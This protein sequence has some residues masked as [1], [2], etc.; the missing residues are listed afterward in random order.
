M[1]QAYP[2]SNDRSAPAPIG[3]PI[4]QTESSRELS[5]DAT[6]KNKR[7]S[8]S[9]LSTL[10]WPFRQF[11]RM[12]EWFFGIFS[13]IW[14]LTICAAIPIL[15]FITLGYLLK[16]SA[17]IVQQQKLRAGFVGIRK[18]ARIGGFV[19]GTT[20]VWF[21]AFSSSGTFQDAQILLIDPDKLRPYQINLTTIIL[22]TIPYTLWAWI[23]GAKLRHFLWPAPL[24]FFRSVGKRKTY[25]NAIE[26]FW[27]FVASLQLKELFM[28]GLR[29]FLGT[30][31]WLLIPVLLCIGGTQL[32]GILRVLSPLLGLPMLAIVLIYLP[33]LQT[34]FAVEKNFSVF[35][36]VKAVRAIF[37]R[38]PIALWISMLLVW[39]FALPVYLAKIQLTPREVFLL[40]TVIFVIFAWPSRM[41]MGWAYGRAEKRE[42]NR[43][44][45]SIWLSRLAII[46]IVFIFAGVVFLS[47]YTSWYGDWSL[48][49]QHALLI[50][51]PLLGG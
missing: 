7:Q 42:K 3:E 10:S 30:A 46:P 13:M 35:R 27:A 4:I 48:F 49:E 22:L 50:P 29:G 41:L 34:R 18:A 25:L 32:P 38:A 33:I 26:G 20:L 24:R 40:P 43:N 19:L 31:A 47:R 23:R 45:I 8:S 36:E 9:L 28:L 11:A 51:I 37:K 2:Q 39:A 5:E 17:E 16:M 15:Q 1:N 21:P 44:T 6:G 12:A 14:L